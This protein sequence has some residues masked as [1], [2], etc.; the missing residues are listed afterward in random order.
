MAPGC[1]QEQ[2][3]R[4]GYCARWQLWTR[5][6]SC[7]H[8]CGDVFPAPLERQPSRARSCCGRGRLPPPGRLAA[9]KLT[10][11]GVRWHAH[12]DKADYNQGS[13]WTQGVGG[14]AF[15][16]HGKFDFS[17]FTHRGDAMSVHAMSMCQWNGEEPLMADHNRSAW[18]QPL[19]EKLSDD[20]VK[21]ATN[22]TVG[23]RSTASF[24][25]LSEKPL[26]EGLG[27]VIEAMR[28]EVAR[29][30]AIDAARE[31]A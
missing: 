8:R 13:I 23:N 29:H 25:A 20:E 10:A 24:A 30:A 19:H 27:E 2:R 21:I 11:N 14:L 9:P 1:P 3:L 22:L 26:R 7:F 28:V 12:L 5:R 15:E 18:G 31:H 17:Y 4:I 6:Q 16:F